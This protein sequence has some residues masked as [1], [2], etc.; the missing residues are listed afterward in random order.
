MTA[1]SAGDTRPTS[2]RQVPGR[3]SRRSRAKRYATRF[4]GQPSVVH[5]PHRRRWCA[6]ATVVEPISLA[7]GSAASPASRARAVP[8]MNVETGPDRPLLDPALWQH[9][10]MRRALAARDLAAVFRLLRR[11]GTSQRTIAALTGLAPSEVYEISRGQAGDG[12]RR[13]LPDR[14]RPGGPARV[15]GAAYD[16]ETA[17]FVERHLAR[18]AQREHDLDEVG[19]LLAH[20]AEVAVGMQGGPAAAALGRPAR[21]RDPAPA[22]RRRADLDQIEA[23]TVALR[24]LDHGHGGGACREAVVAQ[25]RV[26]APAL[27]PTPPRTCVAGCSS[28]PP[29]STTSPAGPRSTSGS[30]PRPAATLP[31]P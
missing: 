28:R 21:G 4:R 24:G 18:A 5:A 27:T 2:R 3:P 20:A 11:V 1:R 22:A 9:A 17:A 7:S 10:D 15:P 8:G 6:Q 25:T 13:A 29:T 26:G 31:A 14:R 30:T 12:L 23:I 16:S 19:A